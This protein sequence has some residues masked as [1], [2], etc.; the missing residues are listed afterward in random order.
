MVDN[1][2][3][4]FF[5]D[6]M[7]TV[8]HSDDAF[9]PVGYVNFKKMHLE[10]KNVLVPLFCAQTLLSYNHL[11]VVDVRLLPDCRRVGICQLCSVICP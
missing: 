8:I 1:G 3:W 5:S 4:C 6:E 10:N 11:N 9:A 7:E 2:I